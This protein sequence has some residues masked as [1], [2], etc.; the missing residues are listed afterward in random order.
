MIDQLP[1]EFARME[2]SRTTG[3]TGHGSKTYFELRSD[4]ADLK[5]TAVDKG[6]GLT[7]EL[8]GIQS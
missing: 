7:I 2:F 4:G 8:A 3:D 6:R 1:E 5:V